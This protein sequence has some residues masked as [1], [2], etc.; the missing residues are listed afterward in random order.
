[1]NHQNHHI[2]YK[3]KDFLPLIII[4][5]IIIIFTIA[6]AFITDIWVLHSTMNDFMGSFFIIFG[7]FKVINLKKFAEAYATYDLI[8]KRS[9]VYAF[10]YPFVEL[11]LGIGYLIYLY[12]TFINSFT[13]ALMLIS[14]AGVAIELSKGKKIMC[15]CL[16]AVFKIPMTYVTLFEDLLMALMALIMLLKS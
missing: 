5:S 15:A 9:K 1:M 2:K 6:K 10:M 4:F 16:G 13:F 14:A 7:F 3:I 11:T 12:P 8:A